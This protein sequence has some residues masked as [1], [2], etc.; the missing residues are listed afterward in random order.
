MITRNTGNLNQFLMDGE[1]FPYQRDIQSA[2]RWLG[3][4]YLCHKPLGRIL[5][6]AAR[7]SVREQFA[8]VQGSPTNLR[9]C[10]QRRR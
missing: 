4:R 1:E 7:D 5:D 9:V 2:M 8:Q 10:N 6:R 3:D